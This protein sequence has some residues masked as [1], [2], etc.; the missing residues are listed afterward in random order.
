MIEVILSRAEGNDR[1]YIE[2]SRAERNARNDIAPINTIMN[3]LSNNCI[4]IIVLQE[5]S[6][7]KEDIITM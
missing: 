2:S 4:S 3:F 6:M 7:E 5:N 1:S